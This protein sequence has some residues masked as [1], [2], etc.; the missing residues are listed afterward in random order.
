MNFKFFDAVFTLIFQHFC[1]GC[2]SNLKKSYCCIYLYKKSVSID[3][4]IIK[5][6]IT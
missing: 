1:L 5:L 3:F 6:K 2:N 4:L